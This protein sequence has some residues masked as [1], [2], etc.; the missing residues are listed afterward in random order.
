[1]ARSVGKTVVALIALA[2]SAC[3]G[4]GSGESTGGNIQV[5][6][7]LATIDS[8]SAPDIAAAVAGA[9]VGSESL[10]AIGGFSVPSVS[11][12]FASLGKD[13]P[14]TLAATIGPES[15]DC[16]AAGSVTLSG[17]VAVPASLTPGDT[18]IFEFMDCD[19]A[20]G[21]VVDGALAFEIVAFSG[22]I[23]IGM[24]TLTV[25]MT[26]DQL[27]FFQDGV[28]GS[29]D[30]ELSFTVDTTNAPESF[31]AV[32]SSLFTILAGGES[33]TISDFIV[34]I[35][36]DPALGATTLD[37]SATLASAAFDGEVSYLTTEALVFSGPGGPIAGQ[38]VVTGAA[39]ATLTI[40]ILGADQIE[41]E[42]D[43]DG[44]ETVDEVVVTSWAELIG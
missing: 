44:N 40:S 7:E 25:S 23:A 28:G 38:I 5:S 14:Q 29:M 27:Q 8:Q 31:V 13:A 26:L 21:I 36:I 34:T 6:A 17:T 12:G 11:T 20:E 24:L 3:G 10:A 35:A 37:S 1:M 30:G 19:D 39:G 41:L 22:E 43:V 18:L 4:S 33:L 15:V 2:L 16:A 42:I 9:I 32:S